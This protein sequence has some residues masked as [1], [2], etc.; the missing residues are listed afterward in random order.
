MGSLA[1]P[2]P[3]AS[4]GRAGGVLQGLPCQHG[5]YSF[6]EYAHHGV[7][8][9]CAAVSSVYLPLYRSHCL[10]TLQVAVASG[11]AQPL[12]A[13]APQSHALPVT[14]NFCFRVSWGMLK[15]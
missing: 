3:Q 10:T 1:G 11:A 15:A 6:V 13:Q 5:Y 2:P 8:W 7:L 4:C 14:H 9:C 12:T